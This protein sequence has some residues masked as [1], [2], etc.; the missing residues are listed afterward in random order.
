MEIASTRAGSF[1]PPGELPYLSLRLKQG[2]DALRAARPLVAD[3]AAGGEGPVE[4]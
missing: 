1:S 4:E 3:Y 2:E